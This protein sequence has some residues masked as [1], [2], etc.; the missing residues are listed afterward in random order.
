[1]TKATNDGATHEGRAAVK[2]TRDYEFP[3]EQIFR[4]LTDAKKASKVWGPDGS[5]KHVF[6]LDP[7]PG[8]AIRIHDGDSERV[9]SRTT[10]T[11]LEFIPPERFVF[12]SVTTPDEGTP[13][14][15][16][17]QTVTLEELGPKKTR[18]TVLVKVLEAGS[19]EGGID[20]LEEGFRA[21]WG[22]TLDMLRRELR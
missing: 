13:P 19:F 12:R 16:A 6:E 17:L 3:R 22:D 10:G 15:E 18:L 8:G 20:S 7:R 9:F 4:L 1:M 21:G 2:I 5:V 11:I 14:W